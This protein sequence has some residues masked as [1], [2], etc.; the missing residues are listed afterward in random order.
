[1]SLLLGFDIGGTNVKYMVCDSNLNKI[2]KGFFPTNSKKGINNLINNVYLIIEKIQ[3]KYNEKIDSIGIGCTGPIDIETGIIENPYTL[4]GFEN[5]S[6]KKLLK[7]KIEIP[8]Y[9]DNDANTA[10]LGEIYFSKSK[11]NNSVMLTFGTGVGCSVRINNSFLRTNGL[12]HSEI[13]HMFVSK[14]NTLQQCYCGKVCCAENTLSGTSLNR[15]SLNLFN[16]KP[17]EVF[18]NPN[19]KEKQI[20]IQNIKDSLFE[21]VFQLSII[22]EPEEVI[23]GGGLQDF[24]GKYLIYDLQKRL[25]KFRNVF[26]KT[27]IIMTQ[28]KNDSGAFGAICTILEN[29]KGK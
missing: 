7:Q 1:M 11:I 17:E 6:I 24:Y 20:F 26:G 19:S 28:L 22:F 29:K 21:F 5:Q 10:H 4:P 8:V 25:N 12:K 9:I 16:L 2:D 14:P 3:N 23:I 18:E 27:K 15:D 13:G